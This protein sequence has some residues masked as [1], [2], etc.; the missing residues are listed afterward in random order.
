MDR[1]DS[2][3]MLCGAL[4][5]AAGAFF[6]L[7]A[8]TNYQLGTIQRMGSGMFPFGVGIVLAI[9]GVLI[10]VTSLL[11]KGGLPAMEVRSPVAVL[12]SIAVFALTIRP[13]G[14]MPSIIAMTIVASLADRKTRPLEVAILSV[15]LCVLA[16]L[17]FR[18]GLNFPITLFRWPF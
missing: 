14:L 8:M 12:A 1:I 3:E 16:F 2:R 13:F 6:A 15:A 11:K 7:Y 10:M 4:V 5:A 17:I 18:I 9:L